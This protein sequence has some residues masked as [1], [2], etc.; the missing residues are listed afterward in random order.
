MPDVLAEAEAQYAEHVRSAH[1]PDDKPDPDMNQGMGQSLLAHPL[2]ADLPLG[3]EAPMERMDAA[4]N[5]AARMELKR[6]LE[7]KLREQYT[8]TPTLRRE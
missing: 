4:E 7:N 5:D 3:T 2:L 6:K 8:S 1:D